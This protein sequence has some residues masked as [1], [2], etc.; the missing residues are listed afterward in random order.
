MLECVPTPAGPPSFTPSLYPQT[1]EEAKKLQA[2]YGSAYPSVYPLASPHDVPSPRSCR[3][4]GRGVPR[5]YNDFKGSRRS[6]TKLGDKQDTLRAAAK[7][8][9][10][11][12]SA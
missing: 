6:V 8:A 10:D 3:R 4:I 1:G 5:I 9:L 12:L 11:G 2:G 7:T